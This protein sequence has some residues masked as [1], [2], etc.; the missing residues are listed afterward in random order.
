MTAFDRGLELVLRFEGGYVNDPADSGGETNLGITATVWHAWAVAQNL[1]P[2]PVKD[3]LVADVAPL[4]REQ[5]WEAGKCDQMP[6][7]IGI[8]HF[9]A[10]VN[11]GVRRAAKILQEALGV[12]PDGDIGPKTLQALR[13]QTGGPQEQG[14]QETSL[15]LAMLDHRDAFYHSLADADPVKRRFLPGWLKRV[16]QL[17]AALVPG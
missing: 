6:E 9:D 5:Y 13:D 14:D 12:T 16:Q 7:R 17:E 4:Y 8:A 10:A 15:L 3:L 2:K 1:P 11:C